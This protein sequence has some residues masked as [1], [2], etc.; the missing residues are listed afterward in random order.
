MIE[1]S[2]KGAK[3]QILR[4]FIYVFAPLRLGVRYFPGES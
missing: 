4:N 1:A 2:R 3:A